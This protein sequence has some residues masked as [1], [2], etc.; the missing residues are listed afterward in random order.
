MRD[1]LIEGYYVVLPRTIVEDSDHG[2]MSS[3]DGPNDTTFRAA[4]GPDGADLHQHAVT[5][6]GGADGVRCDKNVPRETALKPVIERAG[7]RD[8][9]SET[10]PMH[11]EPS[12]HHVLTFGVLANGIAVRIDFDQ[13]AGSDQSLQ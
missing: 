13:L 9:E 5:M 2:R 6:H 8:H 10:V 11:G 12:H 7:V 3:Y 4:V 1:F